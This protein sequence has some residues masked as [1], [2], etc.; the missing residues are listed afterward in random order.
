M[1]LSGFLQFARINCCEQ[2]IWILGVFKLKWRR[3]LADVHIIR[4]DIIYFTKVH[5]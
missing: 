4:F 2:E 1:I 3:D 5:T